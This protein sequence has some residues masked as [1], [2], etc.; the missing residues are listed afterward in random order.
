MT[1]NAIF[2]R[3]ATLAACVGVAVP[4]QPHLQKKLIVALCYG[5]VAVAGRMVF[6]VVGGGV[7]VAAE[8]SWRWGVLVGF[9]LAVV[10]F[11]W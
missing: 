4:P 6:V 10:V 1:R 5:D 8:R 11:F 2:V 9:W 7:A 3:V